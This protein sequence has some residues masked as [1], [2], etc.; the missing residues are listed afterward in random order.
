MTG[1]EQETQGP[2][3][4]ITVVGLE[5]AISAPLCTRHLADLGARVI[6]VEAPGYGDST[7]A[8]DS[9]VGGMSAHFTWLNHGKESAAL[10]L[11]SAADMGI[12]RNILATAD[13]VVSNLAPG[14]LDRLGIGTRDLSRNFPRLIVV[15]ISGYGKGG[16]LDH[17]RAYDLLIQAEGGSCSITGAPGHPAKPGIPVA[18]VGTALYA[19]SAV[20]AALYDRERTGRG[21]VIPIAMLDTVAEMMGFALNQVIHAG[22][23]PVPVGMG[24]PMI[25]PYG[26]YP[27]SDGQTAVL[28]TT[29][30][31]EWRR[32]AEMIGRPELADESRYAHNDN[33]VEARDELDAVVGAWC[34]EH[35]LAE[36]QKTADAAGIG[37]ARLNSVRDLAEHPQLV[38]RGRW[39][40]VGT[41][42]G[43]VPALLPPA[44]AD[45]WPVRSGA[46]PA[47]GAH[48]DAIR[49]EFE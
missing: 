24:S 26:A 38:E 19:Y 31:R 11:K 22:T 20:L 23:E 25:A 41:P 7:R 35:T 29:N 1:T 14:A 43:P 13:V 9:V 28:G 18:D 48:T 21:A 32:L 40:E 44:V 15:D 39:R 47:L 10:D 16:P 6:K 34:A 36:I 30:D 2:L 17:K 3:A 33:R 46:V 37:N 49:V 12:F 27:T 8:Y 5:Q 4:G 45:G 42:S